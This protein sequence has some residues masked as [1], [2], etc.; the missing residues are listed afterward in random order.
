MNYKNKFTYI[1]CYQVCIEPHYG[2]GETNGQESET[3]MMGD[4]FECYL[5]VQDHRLPSRHLQGCSML[6]A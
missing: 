1:P 4:V 6:E 2:L 5:P 3:F